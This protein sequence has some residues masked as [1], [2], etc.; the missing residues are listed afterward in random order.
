[1]RNPVLKKLLD[2]LTLYVLGG[3]L[4][5]KG[6]MSFIPVLGLGAIPM[7]AQVKE[8]IVNSP[9]SAINGKIDSELEAAGSNL[10]SDFDSAIR[11]RS[12]PCSVYN[13]WIN[14]GPWPVCRIGPLSSRLQR[15]HTPKPK[16]SAP[17]VKAICW[18]IFEKESKSGDCSLS[19]CFHW[20]NSTIE[21]MF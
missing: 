20:Q 3:S 12:Q 10:L 19:D 17:Y 16:P 21:H 4:L 2:K 9:P 1:M 8:L 15:S 7:T 6:A 5:T 18:L 14:S 11:V 13:S